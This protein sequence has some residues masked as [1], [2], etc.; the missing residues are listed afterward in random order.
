MGARGEGDEANA[1]E[2]EVVSVALELRP[3]ENKDAGEENTEAATA[4]LAKPLEE[5]TGAPP[6]CRALGELPPLWDDRLP[7]CLAR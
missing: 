4:L 3:N 6:A 5:K 2:K 7:R 1:E